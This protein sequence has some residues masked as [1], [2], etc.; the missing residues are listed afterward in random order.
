LLLP[1]EASTPDCGAGTGMTTSNATPSEAPEQALVKRSLLLALGGAAVMILGSLLPWLTVTTPLGIFSFTGTEGDGSI[2]MALGAGIALM[3]A[4]GLI[5]KRA[6]L[7][8]GTLIG[9]AGVVAGME[10]L[11]FVEDAKA[12]LGVF[13]PGQVFVHTRPGMWVSVFGCVVAVVAGVY[14]LI[15]VRRERRAT[16]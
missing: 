14:V 16:V 3:A 4:V 6:T 7:V 12:T 11:N 5:Q 13:D 8:S 10:A 9:L 1:Y 2:T 15:A